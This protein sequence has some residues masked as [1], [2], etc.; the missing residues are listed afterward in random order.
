MVTSDEFHPDSRQNP[1]HI[2]II[3]DG[4]R[5]W[6]KCHNISLSD[7][8][9]Q[10]RN[11]LAEITGNLLDYGFKE[12]SLYLSSKENFNRIEQ[13]V[14]A[15]NE[16]SEDAFPHE[17]LNLALNKGLK[18]KIA[19]KRELLPLKFQD[20]IRRVEEQ[21]SAFNSATLNLCIAY[22][23]LDEIEQALLNNAKHELFLDKL[24]INTPVDLVIRT[25]GAN[26]LSNFIPLQCAYARLYFID[27]LFNDIKWKDIK[28][29]LDKYQML[30]RKYGT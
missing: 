15:F 30:E 10:T 27:K 4:G 18:V 13:E 16:V 8:Y 26:L 20:S 3:P 2:G 23:P 6:S 9:K 11:L 17:I 24:W 7:S 5:R 21:T 29:I 22:N 19:G 12:I 25:G 1:T 14:N 28:E